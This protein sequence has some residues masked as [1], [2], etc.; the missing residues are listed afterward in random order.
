MSEGD[1]AINNL[2]YVYIYICQDR[3]KFFSFFIIYTLQYDIK[4]KLRM[5]TPCGFND[6]DLH[7]TMMMIHT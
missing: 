3:R 1:F 2:Y 7:K 5:L 6:Y 4:Y